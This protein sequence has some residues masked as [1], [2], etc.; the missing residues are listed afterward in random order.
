MCGINIVFYVITSI[1]S[2]SLTT[3]GFAAALFGLSLRLL[4][5]GFFWT[6]ITSIFT[7]SNLA[8]LGGNMIFLLIYGF[9]LEEKGFM[10][11]PVVFA[12]LVT[13]L[14]AG[15]F[16]LIFFFFVDSVTLGA[17]GSVFGLLGV[18]YGIMRRYNDPN[19][20]KVLY[21]SVILFVFSSSPNTNVFAHLIGLLVGIFV[22]QTD[23]FEH[24]ND[25]YHTLK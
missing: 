1:I 24:M 17:S 23:Y 11:K 16:S 8:H 6:P 20:R 5:L 10:Y 15:V 14:C 4:S 21:V 2:R 13:G 12:Y 25:K 9:R 22:G 3:S 18:N 7:H 19:A